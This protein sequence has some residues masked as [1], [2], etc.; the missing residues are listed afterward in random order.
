MSHLSADE[1]EQM[2]DAIDPSKNEE[3]RKKIQK[4]TKLGNFA[5]FMGFWGI[6]W[7]VNIVDSC[8]VAD[9]YAQWGLASVLKFIGRDPLQINDFLVWLASIGFIVS[10]WSREDAYM[11]FSVWETEC[12]H[13]LGVSGVDRLGVMPLSLA[14]QGFCWYEAGPVASSTACGASDQEQEE[15]TTESKPANC[16]LSIE[17]V[18]GSW[19]SVRLKPAPPAPVEVVQRNLDQTKHS[20]DKI[21]RLSRY[22]VCIEA[23]DVADAKN[24]ASRFRGRVDYFTIPIDES[25]SSA[26]I[27]DVAMA[28]RKAAT[29]KYTNEPDRPDL[30]PKIVARMTTGASEST[31]QNIST[32]AFAENGLDAVLV[33]GVFDEEGYE[34]GGNVAKKKI[35][36][37]VKDMYKRCGCKH[38]MSEGIHSKHVLRDENDTFFVSSAKGEDTGDEYRFSTLFT[39]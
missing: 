27:V 19:R 2:K 26:T 1:V 13:G 37:N 16:A 17:E 35:V 12:A 34:L 28:A 39:F 15:Q 14:R 33:G 24:L 30:V 21:G 22:G 38:V 25:W 4:E 5:F 8:W 11:R 23:K 6:F 29:C 7:F 10:D 32:A 9:S 20:Y 3:Y 18:E 36:E 31:R